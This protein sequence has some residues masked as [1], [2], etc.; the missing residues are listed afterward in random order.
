MCGLVAAISKAD[1]GFGYKAESIFAQMLYADALRGFDST[2]V[3]GVNKYGN[4]TM[5]KMAGGAAKF[6]ETKESSEFIKDIWSK[7]RIVVGHNRA[8]TKGAVTDENAHPF[9]EDHICL[10]HNGTLHSHK[11]LKD[12][13]VDSHAITHAF[14]ERDYREVIPEL[15]GAYALIWYDAKEKKLHICRNDER[16]LWIVSTATVDYIASEEKML[17]WILTRSGIQK[18]EP[19]YF[20]AGWVYSYDITNLADGFTE[21]KLPEKQS[22]SVVT[23]L[24]PFLLTSKK[25]RAKS[26]YKHYN[27]GDSVI[28]EIDSVIELASNSTQ[29]V[30]KGTTLDA[31]P[32]DFQCIMKTE[33]YDNLAASDTYTGTLIGISVKDNNTRLMLKELQ[34]ELFLQSCNGV[35]VT[36]SEMEEA[37]WMCDR[38]GTLISEK[39]QFWVRY[40]RKIKSLCCENCVAADENIKHYLQKDKSHAY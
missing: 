10:V 27:Y 6:L 14:A 9:I 2:G 16:P 22:K 25:H 4:L 26:L 33:D 40:K 35:I 28:V 39:E 1:N 23:S 17:E 11:H 19:K 13:A 37:G 34:P 7:H 3:Y 29:V 30:V 5:H 24:A 32:V 21:E 36:E 31:E 8:A 15:N 38:C 20:K 18:P 12:V